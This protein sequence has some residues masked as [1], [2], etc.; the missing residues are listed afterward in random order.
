MIQTNE[1]GQMTSTDEVIDLSDLLVDDFDS[2]LE[3]NNLRPLGALD[4]CVVLD[5]NTP[6]TDDEG[7][8]ENTISGMHYTKNNEVDAV[9]WGISP[10]ATTFTFPT[11]HVYKVVKEIRFLKN[12]REVQTKRSLLL[13]DQD[14]KIQFYYFCRLF[15]RLRDRIFKMHHFTP[16]GWELYPEFTKKG[17]IHM[18]GLMWFQT[19]GWAI[20][21]CHAIASEWVKLSKGS[22]RALITHKPNGHTDYA[23]A[24]CQDV[25]A[26]LKYSKK[27]FKKQE[28]I[29][30]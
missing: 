10:H 30:K 23:I 17:M 18:H 14:Q 22:L 12:G 29:F 6:P 21:R 2:H 5:G 4:G 16:W 15:D 27:E 28:I 25:E 24:P 1:V 19:D 9:A 3:S 20:G 11:D 26:W 13:K 7:N 8:I